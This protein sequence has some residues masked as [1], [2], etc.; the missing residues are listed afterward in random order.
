MTNDGWEMFYAGGADP[1]E[2]TRSVGYATSSD[3]ITWVRYGDTPLLTDPG[4]AAESDAAVE[5]DGT[6]YL[7]YTTLGGISVATVTY[8]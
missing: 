1:G 5:V 2:L 7:Y 8:Q 4:G 6:N 3:G